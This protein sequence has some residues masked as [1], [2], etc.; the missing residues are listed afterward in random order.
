[1][2]VLKGYADDSRTGTG[3]KIW[4]IAGYVGADH[5]WE[6]FEE[7][8]PKLLAKHGVPYFHMRELGRPNGVYK[9]WHPLK[10]HYAEMAAFY[11]DMTSIIGECWLTGFF[12]IVRLDDLERF[13]A[14]TGLGLEPYPL[15]A[16]GCILMI[17]NEYGDLTSEVFF[18]RVEKAHSKLAKATKYAESDCYHGAA[19]KNVGLFP[20]QKGGTFR[21]LKPLQAA[22]F[23]AWEL[24]R[25]HLNA[26]EWHS[27][28]GR[29]RNEDERWEEFKLWARK[30]FG[31]D[32][33][34]GRK[35][36][37]ALMERAA[38]PLGIIWDYDQI[39]KANDLRGGVW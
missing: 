31:T 36:L 37:L 29:S 16:Y 5:K 32:E 15:A 8:W 3:D 23:L 18:D 11:D 39:R 35:S 20:L 12:S 24:Q 34:R 22:D 10:E 21:Q 17:A 33:P 26:D 14:E 6:A 25:N 7:K 27:M 38:P 2:A 4:V 30:K 28:P 1:M 13:N 19:L 9:K